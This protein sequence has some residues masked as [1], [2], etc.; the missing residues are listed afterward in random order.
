MTLE[1]E[2]T[3]SKKHLKADKET[4]ANTFISMVY[5][6]SNH[7][8]SPQAPPARRS[9]L[10]TFIVMAASAST[11][12]KLLLR[13][14]D[15]SYLWGDER[16]ADVTILVKI[17]PAEAATEGKKPEQQEVPPAKR[18]RQDDE[19][20]A[21]AASSDDAKA[22]QEAIAQEERQQHD[23]GV[24]ATMRVHGLV[25]AQRSGYKGLLLCGGASMVEGQSKSLTVEV[26]D[27]QGGLIII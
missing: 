23:T 18:P 7:T 5:A 22:A 8:S 3:E 20:A 6:H 4:N 27:E 10:D 15:F 13:K 21:R 25:L 9:P 2:Q 26:N 19:A 1:M 11:D 12:A 17:E 16:M 14:A 24:V